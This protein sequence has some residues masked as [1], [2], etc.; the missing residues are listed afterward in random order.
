[1]LLT[2]SCV[3]AADQQTGNL[4]YHFLTSVRG[5]LGEH[6]LLQL[7]HKRLQLFDVAG[8][9]FAVSPDGLFQKSLQQD[10][11]TSKDPT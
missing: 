3:S 4:L 11:L 1:M 8:C 7:V 2:S 9:K 6:S 10:D 5:R